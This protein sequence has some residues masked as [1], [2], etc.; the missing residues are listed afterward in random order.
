MTSTRRAS[1]PTMFR[2]LLHMQ[3]AR[4]RRSWRPYIVVS[5]VMPAG[6][7]LL[8]HLTNTH[9]SAAERLNVIAGAMLLSESIATIV[10]LSQYVAWLKVS[11]ALDHY[12]VLPISLA[13]LII[14]LTTVYGLFAWPGIFLIAAEGFWLDHLSLHFSLMLIP[15]LLLTSIAMGSIGSLIGLVAP[16]EG[17]AGLF[18]N[19]VM[20]GVLFLGM[21]PI[22]AAGPWSRAFWVLPSTGPLAILKGLMFHDPYNTWVQWVGL[23]IYA[24]VAMTLS[25]Y[26]IK[27]P[28]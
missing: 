23:A 2:V 15:L 8:L 24:T 14:A 18:G 11:R 21:V 9:M 6:I 3:F 20:M 28:Q 1:W 22:A 4:L 10:M 26:V 27:R 12:R 17:L 16:D 5:A 19:L 13:L 25:A 7:V